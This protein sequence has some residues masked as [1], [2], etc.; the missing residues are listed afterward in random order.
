MGTAISA[1]E[2]SANLDSGL[3][4][5][6][7]CYAKATLTERVNGRDWYFRAFEES[8]RISRL[9]QIP[10]ET[11]V[12]VACALSPR[13]TWEQNMPAAES[14]IRHFVSGG[15]V[16]DIGRYI[17]G[18]MKLQRTR[19]S[20]DVPVIAD[21]EGIPSIQ[22]PTKVN[23]VKA[24]WI[25]QGHEWV[26]RGDKVS[27]FLD[28]ILNWATSNAV[29]VDSHA[30]QV[31]FGRMEEGTYSVPKAFYT[32]LAA[33][34]RK[35]AEMVGMTPLAFQAVVWLVKKRV[36]EENIKAARASKLAEKRAAKAAAKAAKQSYGFTYRKEGKM[37]HF[38]MIEAVSE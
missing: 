22:G 12:K 14:V 4:H 29:T 9:Y 21:D 37:T 7:D 8:Q 38:T 6:L 3:G 10:I 11:V 35:V 19:H 26:L 34:Y 23:I 2:C 13:L 17:S 20:M 28:N 30:I 16:P 15:Y 33:D 24:L 32:I 5:L 18:A 31:W 25:L 36:T 1:S 27:S